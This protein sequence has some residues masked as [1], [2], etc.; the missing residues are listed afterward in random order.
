M[1]VRS[2]LLSVL[3]CTNLH[4]KISYYRSSVDNDWEAMDAAEAHC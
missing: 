3:T 2:L 1:H 4:A